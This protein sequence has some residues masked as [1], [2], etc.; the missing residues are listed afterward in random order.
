MS[1][2][3]VDLVIIGGGVVGAAIAQELSRKPGKSIL[4]LEKGPRL[5]EGVTGRNSGVIH[6]GIYYPPGSL[7][8]ETCIEGRKLLYEWC[9]EKNVPFKKTGKWII[10]RADEKEALE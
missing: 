9:A 8:A 4:V 2:I 10:A 6:A 1:I 5:G 7:K 3:E